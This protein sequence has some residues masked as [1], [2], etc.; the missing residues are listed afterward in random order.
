MPVALRA[1]LTSN[2]NMCWLMGQIIGVGVIRGLIHNSSEWSYRIPFGLQ[3][4]FAVPI[5][6][7]V[8]FAPESPWWLIRHEKIAEAKKALLRLTTKGSDE[9]FNPDETVAMMQHTN[10]VE[11]YSASCNGEVL[12]CSRQRIY[13]LEESKEIIKFFKRYAFF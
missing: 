7:G 1:Y 4:A 11:K 3:W 12:G 10:E 6:V 8:F 9:D 2:V 5:L 13:S